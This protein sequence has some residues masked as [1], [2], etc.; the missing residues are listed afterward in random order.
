MPY[1]RN[2]TEKTFEEAL[3]II[4]RQVLNI[5]A[6]AEEAYADLLETYNFAGGTSSALA[7]LLYNTSEGSLTADQSAFGSD[8]LAAGQ[9]LNAI[10]TAIQT[11]ADALRRFS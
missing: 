2:H 7:A 8:A 9:A 10:V 4:T 1:S 5:G 11:N 3:Q 6:K